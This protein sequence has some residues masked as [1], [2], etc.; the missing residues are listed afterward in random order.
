MPASKTICA[1]SAAA[2]CAAK[3]VLFRAPLKPFFPALEEKIAFPAESV[4]V[5]IVLLN[6]A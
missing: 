4:N 1:A 6:D 3:G 2:I 5:T